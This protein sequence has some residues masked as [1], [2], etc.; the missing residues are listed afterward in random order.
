MIANLRNSEKFWFLRSFLRMGKLIAGLWALKFEFQKQS[1]DNQNLRKNFYS[2]MPKLKRDIN[3]NSSCTS[4]LL[5]QDICPVNALEIVRPNLVNFPDNL[6]S[7][8]VPA[9]FSLNVSNCTKCKLCVI[10]CPVNALELTG[11]YNQRAAV[12]LIKENLS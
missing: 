11:S 2:K 9:S 1:R 12:D 4:C 10:I 7:G 3:N 5:C 6:L 8:E